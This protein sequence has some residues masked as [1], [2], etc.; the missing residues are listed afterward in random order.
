MFLVQPLGKGGGD[1]GV[2][3]GGQVAVIEVQLGL[4]G[5]PVDSKRL[6]EIEAREID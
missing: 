3:V 5:L 4:I 2:A 6:N 1:H